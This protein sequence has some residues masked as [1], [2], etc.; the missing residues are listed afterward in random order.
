MMMNIDI[1][2]INH[3]LL[4]ILSEKTP[5]SDVPMTPATPLTSNARETNDNSC[6]R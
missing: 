5:P 4:V 1:E 2:M 3:R 6:L